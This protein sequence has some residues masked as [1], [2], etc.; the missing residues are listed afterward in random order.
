MKK[1]QHE[2]TIC[3][4][5]CWGGSRYLPYAFTEN[6]VAMLS[7]VLRS[8]VAIQVNISIMRAF[9]AIR[10]T[11]A[12]SPTD[13]LAVLQYEMNELKA[14]LEDVFADQNDINEDTRMQIE[15]INQS[16]A[17]LQSEKMRP[18]LPRRKV[19]FITVED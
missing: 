10:Q 19:G 6:G 3:D 2:V 5:K 12:I 4:L 14:Y 13:K 11:V 15:L 18:V 17:G 8:E 1:P 7:S 16:L 9:V